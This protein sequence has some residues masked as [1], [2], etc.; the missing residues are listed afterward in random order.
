[1]VLIRIILA[2]VPVVT[3]G[4]A[5]KSIQSRPP[6]TSFFNPLTHQQVADVKNRLPNLQRGM[7]V[8]D[9]FEVLGLRKGSLGGYGKGGWYMTYNLRRGIGLKLSWDPAITTEERLLRAELDVSPQHLD[10]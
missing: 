6:G 3:V 4:C 7:T 2:T 1:M 9:V 5:S 8:D 10:P